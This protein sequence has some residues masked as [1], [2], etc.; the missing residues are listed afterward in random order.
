M[1]KH[2]VGEGAL[3]DFTFE[4]CI[5]SSVGRN[6]KWL[7]VVVCPARLSVHLKVQQGKDTVLLCND[8][9]EAV[10]TYNDLP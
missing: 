3:D 4:H 6:S 2:T 9:A 5:A 7:Y 8:F 10:A 1:T